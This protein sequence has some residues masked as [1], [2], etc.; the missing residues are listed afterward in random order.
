MHKHKRRI[1]LRSISAVAVVSAAGVPLTAF[2]LEKVDPKEAQAVSL[3]YTD[4]SSTV[5]EKKFP[6]HDRSQMCSNCQ[7]Y[8]A[9]QETANKQVGKIAPCTVFGGKGVS[10]K[11]WCSAYVKKQG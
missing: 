6:K 7:F 3:G 11:G 8:Q 1:V 2:A 5:D 9:A 4:D 10:H